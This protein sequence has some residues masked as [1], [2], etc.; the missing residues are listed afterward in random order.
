VA[1]LPV[2]STGFRDSAFGWLAARLGIGWFNAN[3][4]FFLTERTPPGATRDN[5][6]RS[7]TLIRLS[8][9]CIAYVIFLVFV[10]VPWVGAQTAPVGERAR[11]AGAAEDSE[12]AKTQPEPVVTVSDHFKKLMDS[13]VATP[14]GAIETAGAPF[15]T[16]SFSQLFT[17]HAGFG[18]DAAGFGQHYGVNLLGNAS[19]KIL[20]KFVL[21]SLLHQDERYLPTKPG[22]AVINRLGHIVRHV[23]L[24][25]SADHTRT[26]FNGS[27]IPNSALTAALSN[28]YQPSEQRTVANNATRF[29]YNVLGFVIGDCYTEFQPELRNLGSRI[30]SGI[31]RLWH[32]RTQ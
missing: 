3:R 24:T 20:G 6:I 16:A 25:R 1:Y 29:G 8:R 13:T 17:S 18:N 31:V 9:N 7:T 12:A 30:K 22:S 15:V 5:R 28:S 4:G 2:V 14:G 32:V 27:G 10:A 23:V 19:G 11:N 21:P 26:V